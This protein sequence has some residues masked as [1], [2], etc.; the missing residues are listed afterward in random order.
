M[1]KE[2]LASVSPSDLVYFGLLMMLVLFGLVAVL[3]YN[4]WLNATSV[5]LS[6]YT[7]RPLRKAT[8]LHWMTTEKVLRYLFRMHD[9]HNQ[10]FDM[11]QAAYCRETGRL[12]SDVYTWYGSIKVDW[13]FLQKRF[14]GDYV[15]WGSLSQEQ[16]IIIIDRHYSLEGFQTEISSPQ[17]SPVKIEPEYAYAKPGPLYVDLTT[18]VLIGWKCVPE[19]ELEVLIV[20]KPQEIYIPGLHKKY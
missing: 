19:T 7:G 2:Y 10:M 18:S 8:D 16:K 5:S 12:F 14:P 17:P 20:Q 1:D 3:I 4:S 15:S 6:P 9:Y 13:G 11:R